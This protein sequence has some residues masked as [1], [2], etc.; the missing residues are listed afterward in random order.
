MDLMYNYRKKI[1]N[2]A[3]LSFILKTALN[4]TFPRPARRENETGSKFLDS[5]LV[6]IISKSVLSQT[7]TTP[8]M[9]SVCKT[10]QITCIF[11]PLLQRK[12]SL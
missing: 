11:F 5:M 4:S 6:I 3:L 8:N 9:H 7:Q 2:M 12:S 1:T 10:G